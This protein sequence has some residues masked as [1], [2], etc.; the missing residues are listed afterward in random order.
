MPLRLR[1]RLEPGDQR[2]L[3]RLH[4]GGQRLPGGLPLPPLQV[5]PIAK[6]IV[7]G[8]PAL[9]NQQRLR[10]LVH[11]IAVVG[12]HQ[13]RP[14]VGLKKLLQHL[15]RLDIHVV[16]RLVQN[17]EIRPALQKLRQK[18]P[19]F[20]SAR[21]RAHGLRR[22]PAA[23]EISP[24]GAPNLLL[25]HGWKQVVKMLQHRLVG[26][27]LRRLLVEVPDCHLVSNRKLPLERR[28]KSRRRL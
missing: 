10:H 6:G 14:L 24:Q 17:E 15:L 1:N 18:K 2:L 8:S 25:A 5:M 28:H 7:H 9:K 19:G 23:K 21:Q 16:R 20:L 12:H 3:L 22:L 26:F 4:P 11:E 27:H 13:K